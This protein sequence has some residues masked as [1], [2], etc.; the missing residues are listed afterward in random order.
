MSRYA[1]G[2]VLIASSVIAGLLVLAY[3]DRH[4][5]APMIWLAVFGGLTLVLRC[6]ACGLPVFRRNRLW[7]PWPSR[8]CRCGH[9]L[10]E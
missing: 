1:I 5:F 6:P 10:D 8:A 2:V 9:R 7:V 4:P 3:A